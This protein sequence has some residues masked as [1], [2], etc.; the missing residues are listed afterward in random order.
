M[1]TAFGQLKDCTSASAQ[2]GAF[3]EL[4]A[5][6][7]AKPTASLP[8][9]PRS[10]PQRRSA[11]TAMMCMPFMDDWNDECC[12]EKGTSY[13]VTTACPESMRRTGAW[14]AADFELG[15]SIGSGK[16]S[17]GIRCA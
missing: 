6:H 17:S 8:P 16:A 5:N 13:V 11:I 12:L 7:S 3:T 15:R 10:L 4:M 1:R 2:S 9:P 14:T